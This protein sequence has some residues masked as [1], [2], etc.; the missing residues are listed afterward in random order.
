[1]KLKVGLSLFAG[2]RQ[3]Q[4][5][6]TALLASFAVLFQALAF[7]WHQH[8]LPFAASGSA[9]ITFAVAGSETPA[10]T[11]RDCPICFAIAHH[12]AV[13]AKL[14]APPP[15]DGQALRQVP[16]ATVGDPRSRYFLFRSRAP[17]GFDLGSA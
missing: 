12:G 7:G 11:D 8:E 10:S 3:T 5:R 15:P 6:T 4:R 1:M 14:F 9:V 13:P 16:S 17:P 2:S